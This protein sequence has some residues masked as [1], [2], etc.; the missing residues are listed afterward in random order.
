MDSTRKTGLEAASHS[1]TGR[2]S[3]T[4]QMQEIKSTCCSGMRDWIVD[5]GCFGQCLNLEDRSHATTL[6]SI[7]F[8]GHRGGV[9]ERNFRL[10]QRLLHAKA[11]ISTL[12]QL[13]SMP[14][15]S[16]VWGK[17]DVSFVSSDS[18]LPPTT[19]KL[20]IGKIFPSDT[21]VPSMPQEYCERSLQCLKFI[22]LE[23]TFKKGLEALSLRK[24]Y[25]GQD[26][27]LTEFTDH[28]TAKSLQTEFEGGCGDFMLDMV[29]RCLN[30][31]FRLQPGWN[32]KDFLNAYRTHVLEPF[33]KILAA[34][35]NMKV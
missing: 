2:I 21:H 12:P 19:T 29:G 5:G 34:W 14:W 10:K 18:V 4:R 3:R 17:S 25:L 27:Q 30:C 26:R 11:L 31:S 8:D 16:S 33:E 15:V 7:F 23:L 22:S 32:S 13:Q 28:N 6:E 20:Y 1:N 9:D 35:S 24:R